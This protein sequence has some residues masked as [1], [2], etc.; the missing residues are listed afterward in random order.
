MCCDVVHVGRR[1]GVWCDSDVCVTCVGCTGV[2]EGT[3]CSSTGVWLGQGLAG[4]Y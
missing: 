4:T 3:T 2:A 1:E